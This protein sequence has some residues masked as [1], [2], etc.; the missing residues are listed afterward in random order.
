MT[1]WFLTTAF[2]NQTLRIAIPYGLPALGAM[3]SERSGVVNIA[4]EGIMLISAFATTTTTF[5]TGEPLIGILGGVLA[6]LLVAF[7]HSL[8][9]VT[10]KAN[11]IVT[12]IAINLLAL[13]VTKFFCRIIF[14]SSSNSSRIPGLED[15]ITQVPI[16]GNPFTLLLLF[17]LALSHVTLYKTSFGLRLRAVGEHPAA[18]DS[19]GISVERIRYAGV[20]L[21]GIL[22]GLGGAWLALDQHSFT[23]GMTAGRGFIALAAMIIGKWTP[24]GAVLSALFFGFAESLA[25]QLQ[26]GSHFIQFIQMIPYVLT[27]VVLAG[28]IGR[29][30]GPAATGIPFEKEKR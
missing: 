9:T 16:I 7:L 26:S 6:A 13:G 5:Y 10:L 20:L 29:S 22:A 24:L 2:L 4:L 18:A 30:R 3:F 11:Q 21:S 8:I 27:M 28:F 23:D 19:L 15:W 14:E 12:G 17:C 25:I 1:E